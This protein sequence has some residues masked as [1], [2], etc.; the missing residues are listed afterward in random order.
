M[1]DNKVF[2]QKYRPKNFSD[3]LGQKTA[4]LVLKN[5]VLKDRI[6]HAYT[7]FG[8]R[9]TGKTT[10]ARIFA[11]AI[12]CQKLKKNGDPCNECFACKSINSGNSLDVVEID[13]ASYT[14]VDNIREIIE[15]VKF[16]PAALNYKV[17][18]IDEV[19]MLSKGAFNALLK[20]LEEPPAHV[21]FVL[22]TT[23]VEK[24][25]DTIL[26]RTIKINFQKLDTDLIFKK[27]I[28]ITKKEKIKAENEAL[29]AIAR[30]SD[31]GMRDAESNLSKLML[32]S[33]NITISDVKKLFHIAGFD[34]VSKLFELF[35]KKDKK[36]LLELLLEE[37][38]VGT[39][40]LLFLNDLIWYLKSITLLK[41]DESFGDL[42]KKE[43][44]DLQFQNILKH[45]KEVQD[46]SLYDLIDDLTSVEQKMRAVSFKPVLFEV[47]FLKRI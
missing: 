33:D 27:L 3:V 46:E 28:E 29:L 15:G 11:K 43:L 37:E 9:G 13:A 36:A 4:V 12:N 25:P 19:H 8:P 35:L 39:D 34:R 2:Y 21:V 31:G 16:N 30:I 44:T 14:G 40:F 22:A 5:S 41:T 32:F 20:T 42:I 26:S 38:K 1:Q 24:I 10:L 23:E 47:A 17:I 6:F 7:F 45:S 18:I